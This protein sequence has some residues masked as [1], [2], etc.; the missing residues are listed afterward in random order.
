VTFHA[1]AAT[2][3]MTEYNFKTLEHRL[4]ELA[5][6]NSGVRILLR[7]ERSA[8][9]VESELFYEGGVE[10]FCRYLDRSCAARK[11]ASPSKPRFGGM[12][13]TTRT[14]LP[15]R[16]TFRSETAERTCRAFAG[17]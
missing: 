15:L 10:A 2:F 1:S 12:T 13:V 6:L 8:E 17:R 5:F 4:R 3:T 9:H 11:T 7:D 14:S 16:T